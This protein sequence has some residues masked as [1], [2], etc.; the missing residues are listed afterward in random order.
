MY[1]C[2]VLRLSPTSRASSLTPSDGCVGVNAAR[3]PRPRSSD[4]EKPASMSRIIERRLDKQI[5]APVRSAPI[6]EGATVATQAPAAAVDRQQFIAGEWVD[7]PGGD[8]FD[9]LD[10]FTGDV[11]ARIPAGGRGDARRAIEAAAAAF[12]EWSQAPPAQRQGIFLKA[13]DLLEARGDDIVSWLARE[14]GSTFGFATFQLHFVAGLLR[15]A[16]ALAYAPIGQI[17]PS[18]VGAF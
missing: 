13:A 5:S 17:I 14:T 2:V 3:M 4:C 12:P 18:D 16:A 10:P 1:L 15:Q 8:T 7:A 9:D 11:V 6:K